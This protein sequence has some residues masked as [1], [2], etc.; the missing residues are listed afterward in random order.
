MQ[1]LV[2]GMCYWL[3]LMFYYYY[4]K[5]GY[6]ILYCISFVMFD[7]MVVVVVCVCVCFVGV[8]VI[9]Q[10]VIDWCVCVVVDVWWFQFFVDQLKDCWIGVV[11]GM[12]G[13][14]F[15]LLRFVWMLVMV[16]VE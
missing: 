3:L 8:D 10:C 2:V 5:Y 4:C 11:F 12:V 6:L 1:M 9:V 7:V 14:Y 16:W 15:G 13:G